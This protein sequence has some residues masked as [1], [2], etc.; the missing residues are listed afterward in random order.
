MAPV[1][2]A[3]PS[4]PLR[5]RASGVPTEKPAL[6]DQHEAKTLRRSAS[7]SAPGYDRRFDVD[8]AI[9]VPFDDAESLR[10]GRLKHLTLENSLIVGHAGPACG[11]ADGQS[12]GRWERG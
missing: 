11:Q 6:R 9:T 10:E 5:L 8:H 7:C 1:S 3:R 2:K 12:E 4:A